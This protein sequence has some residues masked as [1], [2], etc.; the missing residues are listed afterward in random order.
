MSSPTTSTGS[1]AS[2]PSP[3]SFRRSIGRSSSRIPIPTSS[4][5]TGRSTGA[6]REWYETPRFSHDISQV[7]YAGQ[8]VTF[9]NIQ[10]GRLH[11][12]Q[13]DLPGRCR[14]RLQDPR[15]RQDRRTDDHLGRRR[16]QPLPS[17]LLREGQAMAPSQARQRGARR[18]CARRRVSRSPAARSST[19]PSVA[20][21]RS[22]PASTTTTRQTGRCSPSRTTP[23]TTCSAARW[24][25]PPAR[26]KSVAV[27]A[28]LDDA[29]PSSAIVAAS[30]LRV[31]A[32]AADA[33]VLVTDVRPRLDEAG[34]P[35]DPRRCR[36]T[37]AD[38]RVSADARRGGSRDC[39]SSASWRAPRRVLDAVRAR[40]Q[41]GW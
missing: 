2:M 7:I 18:C 13:R 9:L 12:L 33:D 40:A 37:A 21:W 23:T 38:D 17:R 25:G 4:R 32:S 41:P 15:R 6:R 8:T 34:R 10:L 35:P 14:L 28:L 24:S 1:T 16:P 5:P 27:D 30:P 3:S 39:S 19:R 29:D 20:S 11:G 36:A 26:G 22:S 31:D